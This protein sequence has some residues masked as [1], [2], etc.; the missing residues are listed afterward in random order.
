MLHADAVSEQ[1]QHP[2]SCSTAQLNTLLTLPVSPAC[3]AAR[4]L[5]Q[6]VYTPPDQD[7]GICAAFASASAVATSTGGTAV[8]QAQASAKAVCDCLKTGQGVAEAVA[9]AAASGNAQTAAQAIAEAAGG[10]PALQ[11]LQVCWQQAVFNNSTQST[12]CAST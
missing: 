8:S 2:S 9:Q 5:H 12:W 1:Q 7:G 11:G 4:K 10:E 6:P 3:P